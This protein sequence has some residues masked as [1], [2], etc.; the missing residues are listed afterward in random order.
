M[1]VTRN[2]KIPTIAKNRFGKLVDN[3]AIR[4]PKTTKKRTTK[5]QKAQY[6]VSLRDLM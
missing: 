4:T 5:R 3:K 1:V 2:K 6:W